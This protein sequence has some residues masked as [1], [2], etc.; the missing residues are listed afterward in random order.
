V[1]FICNDPFVKGLR[2]LRGKAIVVHFTVL[3]EERVVKRL[4]EITE[5][6]GI[7]I[8][9]DVLTRISQMCNNDIRSAVGVLELIV[10][11]TDQLGLSAKGTSFP[12]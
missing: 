2:D 1:I 7:Y 6:E 9:S 12:T 11:L 4:K 8:E 5:A 10:G 3:Q